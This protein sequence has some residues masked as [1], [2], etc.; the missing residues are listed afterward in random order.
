MLMG[1]QRGRRFVLETFPAMERR[2]WGSNLR[3][4]KYIWKEGASWAWS[5]ITPGLC[6]RASEKRALS[7]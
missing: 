1:M 4:L 6:N 3:D 5:L 2:L 7:S